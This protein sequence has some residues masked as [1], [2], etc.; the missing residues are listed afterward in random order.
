MGTSE[1]LA[2]QCFDGVQ[3]RLYPLIFAQEALPVPGAGPFFFPR[4]RSH[5]GGHSGQEDLSIGPSYFGHTGCRFT[6]T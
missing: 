2:V 3:F 6:L 4:W 1:E 5:S